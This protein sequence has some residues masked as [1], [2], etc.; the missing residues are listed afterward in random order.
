MG[1]GDIATAVLDR[2][3]KGRSE[4]DKA[5]RRF[6]SWDKLRMLPGNL[7]CRAKKNAL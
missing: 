7:N 6:Q 4:T 3:M 5:I 2:K 1:K